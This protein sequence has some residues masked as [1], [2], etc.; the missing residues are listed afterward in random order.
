MITVLDDH[1]FDVFVGEALKA[2]ENIGGV[3]FH[4]EFGLFLDESFPD[5]FHGGVGLFLDSPDVEDFD[6][7]LFFGFVAVHA[8][9]NLAESSFTDLFKNVIFIEFPVLETL[10]FLLKFRIGEVEPFVFMLDFLFV[11]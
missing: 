3:D 2:L 1:D 9:V 8:S 7:D 5:K 4:H 11:H 6:G 10:V